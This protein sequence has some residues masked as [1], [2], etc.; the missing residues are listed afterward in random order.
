VELPEVLSR[1]AKVHGVS[2]AFLDAETKLRGFRRVV[3][4]E[5]ILL[6]NLPSGQSG[7]E[8]LVRQRLLDEGRNP[9]TFTV[10]D[11]PWGERWDTHPALI[12]HNGNHYLQTIFLSPGELRAYVGDREVDPMLVEPPLSGYRQGLPDDKA[13]RVQ[14]YNIQNI[15]DL[16]V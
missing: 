12:Q 11:L 14:T 16:R 1:L 5:R 9:D 4:G 13:V 3:T 15:K 2:V 6:F 8:G 7:Y 10:G